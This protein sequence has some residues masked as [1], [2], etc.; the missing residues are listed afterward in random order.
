MP[1]WGIQEAFTL[2]FVPGQR[3]WGGGEPK[4]LETQV[5]DVEAEGGGEEGASMGTSCRATGRRTG[6]EGRAQGAHASWIT[7][8][9]Q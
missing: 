6:F 7:G 1:R 9:P 8:Q 5:P 3:L 2:C 4:L